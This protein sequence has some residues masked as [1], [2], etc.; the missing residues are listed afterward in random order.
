M[1]QQRIHHCGGAIALETP[2]VVADLAL[3]I[4]AET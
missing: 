3:K 1:D 4:E 2:A